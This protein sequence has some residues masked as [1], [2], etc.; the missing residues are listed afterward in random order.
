MN[1]T[2]SILLDQRYWYDWWYKMILVTL[3]KVSQQSGPA[4]W[5]VV[6]MKYLA[7][8]YVCIGFRWFYKYGRFSVTKREL[9]SFFFATTKATGWFLISN[10]INRRSAHSAGK[11]TRFLRRRP[12]K[13][14]FILYHKDRQQKSGGP[15]RNPLGQENLKH[16]A[17]AAIAGWFCWVGSVLASQPARGGKSINQSDQIVYH[18]PP[19]RAQWTPTEAQGSL[20]PTNV[21][22]KSK[23]SIENLMYSC[24]ICGPKQLAW[25]G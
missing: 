14:F 23:E 1:R 25:W 19:A 9:F 21:W 12:V 16:F 7:V 24:V 3:L 13:T 10:R 20:I 4:R 15:N 18:C 17:H 2:L 22:S 6:K 5:W 11:D 8:K